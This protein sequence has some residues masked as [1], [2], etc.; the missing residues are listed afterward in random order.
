M[1]LPIPSAPCCSVLVLTKSNAVS[2]SIDANRLGISLVAKSQVHSSP[3]V[4]TL[5][6]HSTDSPSPAIA[7]T[8]PLPISNIHLVSIKNN[9]ASFKATSSLPNEPS[10]TPFSSNADR[11]SKVSQISCHNCK[12]ELSKLNP[13]FHKVK[14]LPSENWHELLDCWACHQEDYSHLQKGHYGS[15]I[16]S[17]VDQLLVAQNYLLV[18][19]E[20]LRMECVEID[21]LPEIGTLSLEQNL[22]EDGEVANVFKHIQWNSISCKVCQMPLGDALP[23]PTDAA[24]LPTN[25]Y[26][27]LRLY[28]HCLDIHL[29]DEIFHRSYIAYFVNEI[30]EAANSHASYKFIISIG[31]NNKPALMIWLLNW[32][33]LYGFASSMDSKLSMNPA[34]KVG[35]LQCTQE[36]EKTVMEWDADK[37]VERMQVEAPFFDILVA[38]LKQSFEGLIVGSDADKELN[39]FKFAYIKQ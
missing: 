21:L 12:T 15:V 5:H 16:P 9:I 39:G 33:I 25:S 31:N 23:N 26:F 34:V 4:I 11:L 19:E 13:R 28:K 2:I 8:L 7:F 29:E 22:T 37:Q 6:P 20:N 17:R 38:T 36:S 1:T 10:F 35:F 18:H 3:A 14:D 32:N 27:A 24:T 30:L